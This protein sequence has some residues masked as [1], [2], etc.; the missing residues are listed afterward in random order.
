MTVDLETK[1][2]FNVFLDLE[3]KVRGRSLQFG[4]CHYETNGSVSL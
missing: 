1:Y 4:E 3:N 2:F